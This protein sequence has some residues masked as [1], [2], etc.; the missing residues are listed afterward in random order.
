M[1]HSH[2]LGFNV[3]LLALQYYKMITNLTNKKWY[4]EILPWFVF[5]IFWFFNIF[6]WSFIPPIG[7]FDLNEKKEMHEIFLMQYP[8]LISDFLIKN[9]FK[10]KRNMMFS[11]YF[12]SLHKWNIILI[13][14]RIDWISVQKLIMKWF[15]I[16]FKKGISCETISQNII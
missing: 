12:T 5:S 10:C 2:T 8:H 14:S 3:I 13:W 16:I 7:T 15:L 1:F 11:I 9:W 6:L 4:D